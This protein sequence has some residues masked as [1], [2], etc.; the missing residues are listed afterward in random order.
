MLGSTRTSPS[1]KHPRA[2]LLGPGSHLERRFPHRRANRGDLGQHPLRVRAEGSHRWVGPTLHT[3][4]R[5]GDVPVFSGL[6]VC[7]VPETGR[8]SLAEQRQVTSHR[9]GK[10]PVPSSGE[11]CARVRLGRT[12]ASPT[13]AASLMPAAHGPHLRPQR[14][15]RET[16]ACP[17]TLWMRTEGRGAVV[18]SQGHTALV[19]DGE[20]VN[21]G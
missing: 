11:S 19:K 12:G 1:A 4:G 2:G 5:G 18:S 15:S 20:S 9:W 21:S 17:P 13:L 10:G 8:P 16:S 7:S 14:R 3:Q 6:P